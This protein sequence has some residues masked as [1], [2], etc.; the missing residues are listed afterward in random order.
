[1]NKTRMRIKPVLDKFYR[2]YDFQ[3][4]MRHDPIDFPHRYKNTADIEVSGF[5]ASCFAYGKVALFKQVVGT[6]L[7]V[8][9]E[10][11]G[12]FLMEFNLK[13]QRKSFAGIIYRFNENDDILCLLY[14]I[15]KTLVRH[16]SLENCFRRFY[17]SGDKT[18][19]RGLSGLV[20]S[21]LKT[22][23]SPVYGADARPPGL[24]Q[25]FPVPENG[26]ACKRANLFL[27]WMIRDRDIDFGI[28]KG[29]PR[30]RLVIPLD[31]H[32]ARISRCL[33][34]TARSSQDWKMAVEITNSLKKLDP[35]DPLKYD[36]ALCHHGI[37][38]MCKA[39]G[40]HA[41]CTGCVFRGLRK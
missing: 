1:M 18:I 12:G 14:L 20:G 39:G 35:E 5:I 33:G 16:G 30:D 23:T 21:F 10:S 4:R 34:L 15:H 2:E 24:V 38:G 17:E 31:T 6:I 36:F 25:F 22:D 3:E 28:W 37:S 27:R 13:R 29:V 26:S 32:I 9:G 8:M 7:S 41:A 19:E 11:P 40:V